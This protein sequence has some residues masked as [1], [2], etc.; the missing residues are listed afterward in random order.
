MGTN[1]YYHTKKA[2][3]LTNYT[4]KKMLKSN[5]L[6]ASNTYA[7]YSSLITV[8]P[9]QIKKATDA[10]ADTDALLI[11]VN[12]LFAHW[13]K[14]VDIKRYPD[15]IYIL[16]TNHPIDIYKY[17]EKMLKYLPAKALDTIKGTLLYNKTKVIIPGGQDR[18]P[19]TSTTAADRTNANLGRRQTK[20]SSLISHK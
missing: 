9:I 10:S 6:L 17:S 4:D 20:F 16:P 15:N 18:R 1:L 12:N 13:L 14:E 5:I 7:N 3:A 11:T 2:Y 8:L 19:N